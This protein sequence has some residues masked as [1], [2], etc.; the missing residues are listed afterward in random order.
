MVGSILAN[1]LLPHFPV[2]N[3]PHVQTPEAIFI[4]KY[5]KSGAVNKVLDV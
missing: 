2:I 5:I 1:A 3:R 4:E